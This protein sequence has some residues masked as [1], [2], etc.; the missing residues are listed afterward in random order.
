LP[1]GAGRAVYSPDGTTIA[2]GTGSDKLHLWDATA[3]KERHVFT[4]SNNG[5]WALPPAG[6]GL[7]LSR[8]GKALAL[9]D[10]DGTIRLYDPAAG[11]E[12]G[13]FSIKVPNQ[14]TVAFING[15]APGIA[16]TADGSRL[17]IVGGLANAFE[18]G[19]GVG[20]SVVRLWD[21]AKG[22]P[23]LQFESR[24]VDILSLTMAPNGWMLATSHGDGT[25]SLWETTTGKERLRLK[26]K[27]GGLLSGVSEAFGNRKSDAKLFC[28]AFSP[29]GRLL[30]G[31]GEDRRVHLW[32]LRTGKKI[33]ALAGHE[34][35]IQSLAF[36]PDSR[37]LVSGSADS[38]A[39]CFDLAALLPGDRAKEELEADRLQVLWT[40]LAGD[41]AGKAYKALLTLSDVPNQVL[42][43]ARERVRPAAGV[44]PE[45]VRLLLTDLDSKQFLVRQ[46]ASD[47]LERYAELVEDDLKRALAGQP[48]LE[49]RMRLEGLLDRIGTGAALP[50]DLLEALRTLE[51]LELI[52]TADA[53]QAVEPLTKGVARARLTREA[54][55]VEQRLARRRTTP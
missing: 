30:A 38:T 22:R 43:L 37:S 33:G 13:K 35:P 21:T 54:Q 44:A 31:G 36:L 41:D 20:N 15:M 52:G 3:G 42:P 6:G 2:F 17:A 47:L 23:T 18:S 55:A 24:Q 39:L 53:R 29:D 45:R 26:T 4:T 34:G 40:D 5:G 10:Y 9:R 14:P 19:S 8:D 7:A 28:L 50:S 51:L 12:S 1:A 11:K 32:D 27:E 16:Y 46:R 48:P 25:V 49:V